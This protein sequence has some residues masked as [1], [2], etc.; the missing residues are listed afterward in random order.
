MHVA[1]FKIICF[2]IYGI[3]VLGASAGDFVINCI[4]DGTDEPVLM[5][6]NS[7]P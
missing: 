5:C 6:R 4:S 3:C 2:Y 7:V 1:H